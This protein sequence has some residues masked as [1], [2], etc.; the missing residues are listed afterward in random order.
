MGLVMRLAWRNLWRQ[1]KRTLLTTGAM[2][3]SNVLLIFMISLQ[4]GMYGLMIENGL[5]IFTGYLQIQAPGY[6]DE[7]KMRLTVGDATSLSSAVR[8]E[9][10]LEAAARGSTFALLSSEQ[11]TCRVSSRKAA[12]SLNPPPPRS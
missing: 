5:K 12:I 4:F 2:V 10:G 11:R 6:I 9:S 7:P 1:P 3:F 8:R